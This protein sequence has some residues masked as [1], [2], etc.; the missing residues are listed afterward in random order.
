MPKK[1]KHAQ[2]YFTDEEQKKIKFLAE[3]EKR[4]TSSFLRFLV[5]KNLK[6]E[7]EKLSF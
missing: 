6:M 2:I 7:E 1:I 4:T 3:K 5:L